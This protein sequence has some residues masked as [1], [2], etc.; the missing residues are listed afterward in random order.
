MVGTPIDKVVDYDT[1]SRVVAS[2]FLA[3]VGYSESQIAMLLRDSKTGK[4]IGVGLVSAMN[5]TE[6]GFFYYIPEDLSKCKIDS[7]IDGDGGNVTI[8]E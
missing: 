6:K 3:K 2:R 7:D 5:D 1:W 8:S 4:P